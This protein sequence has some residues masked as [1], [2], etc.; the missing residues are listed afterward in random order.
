MALDT[1]LQRQPVPAPLIIAVAAAL[2]ALACLLAFLGSQVIVLLLVAILASGIVVAQSHRVAGRRRLPLALLAAAGTALLVFLA[3][4]WL[5]PGVPGF[6][7]NNHPPTYTAVTRLVDPIG[8]LALFVLL[9][10]ALG[11][12]ALRFRIRARRA[13]LR[14]R[15]SERPAGPNEMVVERAV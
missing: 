14:R 7:A 11:V 12:E 8:E 6:V 1:A 10:V 13:A 5:L 4:S 2:A 3:I 15:R 9:L